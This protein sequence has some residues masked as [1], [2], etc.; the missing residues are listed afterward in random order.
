MTAIVKI[1]KEAT[2]GMIMVSRNLISLLILLPA[3]LKI[4][5]AF[6]AEKKGL[7]L[8]RA[9]FSFITMFCFYVAVK[10]LFLMDAVLLLNTGPLFIP[11]IVSIWDGEVIEKNVLLAVFMGFLGVVFV[12]K[13]GFSFFNIFGLVGL[14]SGIGIAMSKVTMKKLSKTENMVTI[15]F[16]FFLGNMVLGIFPMVYSW[17]A[18]ENSMTWLYLFL[19]GVLS[20]FFQFFSTKA[21]TNAHAT[22]VGAI[23]YF[24]IILSAVYGWLIWGDIPDIFTVMGMFLISFGGIIILNVRKKPL[25]T[26]G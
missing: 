7:L 9:L 10:R 4:K 1:A 19:I 15:L 18:V 26:K 14:L 2:P 3:F 16:Y 8:L 11:L 5:G 20:F 13:P 25:S 17:K 12:L 22:K 6:R 24:S 21:Y 23:F